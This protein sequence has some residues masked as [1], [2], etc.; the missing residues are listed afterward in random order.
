M[1]DWQVL[2]PIEI[3]QSFLE[4]VAEYQPEYPEYTAQLLWQRGICDRTTLNQFLNPTIY[5]PTS[6]FTA[7]GQQMNWAIARLKKAWE[8]QEKVTIW[9]D[10]DADGV[11][12]TSVL[13]EGLLPFFSPE[14]LTYYIPNRLTESHGLNQQGLERL[15]AKGVSLVITCDTGSTNLDEIEIAK[16]LGIDIM[17]T[18]HHTLPLEDPDVVAILNPRYL[19]KDHP[20]SSLSGV[21]VA[22]KLIESLYE[23]FPDIPNKPAEDLLDLV[24][25]GLIADLVELRGD[26]RYL[27]Q[28][29]IQKLAQQLNHPTRPG[30][31]KL[32]KLCK[33]TGDRPM[34]IS[35]G[36]GPRINAISRIQ[37]DA[38]FAVELL[39][40]EDEKLCQE[41]ARKTETANTRRKELQKEMEQDVKRRVNDLDLSTTGVIILA[42]AQWQ[43]GILGLVAGK[44]AQEYARPTILLNLDSSGFA[45]GSARSVQQIDLYELLR[46]KQHLLHRFGGHPFAAGL[47]LKVEN[48][49]IFQEAINQQFR[50]KYGLQTPEPIINIDLTVTVQELGK[51]LFKSLKLLEPYGMGN[52]LPRLLIKNCW[53]TEVWNKNIQDYTK[54][55]VQYIRTTFKICDRTKPEGFHGMWW[56]HYKDELPEN[57]SFDAVVELDLNTYEKRH[58]VRLI[59]LKI[60]EEKMSHHNQKREDILILDRRGESNDSAVIMNLNQPVIKLET[61]PRNWEELGKTLQIAKRENS[62]IALTYTYPQPLSP[63]E[64][65]KQL[66]GI[67]K[68]LSRTG[69]LIT[70]EK[71]QNELQLSR[72]TIELGLA[73]L[74]EI[75]FIIEGEELIKLIGNANSDLFH[76]EKVK[77]FL[78]TV[79]EEQFRCQY[80]SEVPTEVITA[81]THF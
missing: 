35:F 81:A 20:L 30:I 49:S 14:T 10:F 26:C 42:D 12:A 18:D 61:C 9:G 52:P 51:D 69:Q 25:I 50:Q 7:F 80:F 11:T 47:S 48:L 65:W 32:L 78:E 75:G 5:L 13:W 39:T 29:G 57:Q 1:Y 40:S 70:V 33:R 22:Y 28:I 60:S 45:R 2:S 3:P 16:T 77:V 23:S 72:T 19:S 6:G 27:A 17:I 79:R 8:T 43:A 71:L 66:L 34:D 54:K 38:S 67:A 31:A 74:I 41:L 37:G 58:E 55:K 36:L 62:A 15:A 24:A 44:I 63:E 4:A 53:F 21:A 56:G 73:A 59:D 64:I 46:S 76:E 68:Y